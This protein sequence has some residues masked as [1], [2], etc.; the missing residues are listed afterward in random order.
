MFPLLGARKLYKAAGIY[1]FTSVL[2]S[3]FPRQTTPSH[4]LGRPQVAHS[5]NVDNNYRVSRNHHQLTPNCTRNINIKT[6]ISTQELKLQNLSKYQSTPI[7]SRYNKYKYNNHH[8]PLI[9]PKK[10]YKKSFPSVF[11]SLYNTKA[12][13]L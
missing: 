6:L 10:S 12:I 7:N 4:P 8:S 2:F 3:G 1:Q 5:V 9:Q 11:A 13:K